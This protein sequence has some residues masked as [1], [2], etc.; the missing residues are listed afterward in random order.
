MPQVVSKDGTKIAYEKLGKGPVIIVVLG[1]LNTRYSGSKLAQLL[2]EHFTVINYDRRGRGDSAD[3]LPY[4]IEKEIED[5]KALIDAAGGKA[6][7]YGHSSG[8][9][10]AVEV[11]EKLGNKVI[12]LALYE[13]PYNDDAQA[14]KEWGEYIKQLTHLLAENKR[15]DAV[16]LFMKYVGIPEQQI[17]GMRQ[18][19]FWQGLEALAP[20]LAYDHTAILGRDAAIPTQKASK[21]VVPTLVMFGSSSPAFMADTAKKISQI[22]PRATLRKLENQTH[23]V[24][25]ETLVPILRNFFKNM[26]ESEAL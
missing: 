20:T 4:T 17:E 15:G 16:A 3:T 21:V 13:V 12:G 9:A 23:E 1:A 2:S 7:L 25:P 10:L 19:P 24:S 6:Y 8:G 5:I 18:A 22:M 14:K 26:K 11:A